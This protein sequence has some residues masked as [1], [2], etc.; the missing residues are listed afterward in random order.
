MQLPSVEYRRNSGARNL[1][2]ELAPKHEDPFE[3]TCVPSVRFVELQSFMCHPGRRLSGYLRRRVEICFQ[4]QRDFPCDRPPHLA[5]RVHSL[6]S[7]VLYEV[8]SLNLPVTSL[9]ATN[10]TG[11]SSLLATSPEPSTKYER[12]PSLARFRPQA[13]STSRRL[14]PP[15]VSWAYCIP[16]PRVGFDPF[17]GFSRLAAALTHR[18]AVPLC[19]YPLSAHHRSSCHTQIDRL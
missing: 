7:S 11:V 14:A 3:K 1:A 16:L 18:Q 4:T 19:R 17:R 9:E 12:T 10:P 8:S 15:P 6:V 5:I 13:F 2:G